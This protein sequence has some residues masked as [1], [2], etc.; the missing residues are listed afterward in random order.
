MTDN[1]STARKTQRL[2]VGVI[3]GTVFILHCQDHMRNTWAKRVQNDLSEGLR[4]IISDNVE[5]DPKLR[6]TT[7]YI[8]FLRALDKVSLYSTF[9]CLPRLCLLTHFAWT[10]HSSVR[11]TRIS[12][13]CANIRKATAR[14]MRNS[15]GNLS[16]KKILI[17]F[18]DTLKAL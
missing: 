12:M 14:I 9:A 13:G 7:S 1:C 4:E 11:L 8:A 3:D 16:R 15:S 18:F 6:C 5:I 10:L 2:F 17:Y